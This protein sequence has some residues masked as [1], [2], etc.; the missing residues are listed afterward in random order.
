MRGSLLGEETYND[1]EVGSSF[2]VWPGRRPSWG[3][4]AALGASTINLVRLSGLLE[5][6][7]PSD[8]LGLPGVLGILG[9]SVLLGIATL[10]AKVLR[11]SA[12]LTLALLPLAFVPAIIATIP[13]SVVAPDYVVAD[14]PFPVVGLVLATVGCGM[15]N[16]RASS[17]LSTTAR[18]ARSAAPR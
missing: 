5:D 17:P 16:D 6:A 15:L 14:L 18:G 4:C 11:H 9:G 2:L 1:P 12:R 13:L 8:G 10:R 7:T 3:R